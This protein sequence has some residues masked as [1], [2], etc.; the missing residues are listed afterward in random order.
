MKKSA[1]KKTLIASAA[2][3]SLSALLFAGTT[4][5]WFTDSASSA[6]STIQSGN[7][8]INLYQYDT[9]S[10]AYTAVGNT[11][12]VFGESTVWEPGAVEVQYI[13]VANDGTLALNYKLN[14]DAK[15]TIGKNKDG[16][17][18]DLKNY[19]QVAV[20][21]VEEGATYA[22]RADAVKA[23]QG[24]NPVLLANAQ[25]VTGKLSPKKAETTDTTDE[26]TEKTDDVDTDVADTEKADNTAASDNTAGNDNAAA[27]DASS[28]ESTTDASAKYYA[29]IVYM[30]ETVGNDA[31][32]DGTNAPGI[33]LGVTVQAIQ[34]EEESDSYGSDYDEN[35]TGYTYYASD[36]KGLQETV[37]NA[38]PGSVVK[39]TEDITVYE[40]FALDCADGITVD[41]RAVKVVFA[42]QTARLDLNG[43][44]VTL[45]Y[46]KPANFDEAES[47]F[48]F[49]TNVNGEGSGIQE[50]TID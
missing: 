33:S 17:D 6:V 44:N 2:A 40:S 32:H 50:G 11:T 16:N 18:I 43:D 35:A 14:L 45:L 27:S 12:K 24:A 7:L 38:K 26:S 4:Y 25:D 5:A 1:S 3:L 22:S 29:V 8:D 9:T 41:T 39:L 49:H 13:K 31:N 42:N 34:A 19:L 20:V 36:L 47:G 46:A 15:S 37:A 30:P 21:E 48:F 28:T 23:L 10:K